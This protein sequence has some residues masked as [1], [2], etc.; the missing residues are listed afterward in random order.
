MADE[1]RILLLCYGNPA[2]ADDGLGPAL[3]REIEALGRPGITVE[4]NYQLSVEDSV[5][6]GR[7]DTVLFVDAAVRGPEPFSFRSV[8]PGGRLAFSSHRLEPEFLMSLARDLFRARTSAYALGIR[9]YEFEHFGEELTPRA[10]ANLRSAV[11]FLRELLE[12]GD[13]KR[14]A[15]ELREAGP[16]PC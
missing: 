16:T 10:L 15:G 8:Q 11:D 13:F 12:K 5:E 9:G 7:Y 2:R 4:V 6:I 14:A 1:A 3:A